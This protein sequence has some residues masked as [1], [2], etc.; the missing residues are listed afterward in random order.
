MDAARTINMERARSNMTSAILNTSADALVA[1]NGSRPGP[2][3]EQPG[4]P[5]LPACPPRLDYTGRP[6]AAVCP[7]PSSGRHVVE[8]GREREE[9]IQWED[10][11]LYTEYRPVLVDKMGKGR[12]HRGPLH[13]ADHG[14][15]D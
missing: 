10:R 2:G 7:C 14:G 12:H 6:V 13:R 11:E 9:V 3:P 4:V 5:H 1:V 8:T 15:R